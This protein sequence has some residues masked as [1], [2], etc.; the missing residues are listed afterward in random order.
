MRYAKQKLEERLRRSFE[1]ASSITGSY[2]S[3]G[4]PLEKRERKIRNKYVEM[5]TGREYAIK[6]IEKLKTRL[7]GLAELSF[8]IEIKCA[9][10]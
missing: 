8:D 2:S 3:P 7:H 9:R 6:V 1:A 4:T 5:Y 10:K